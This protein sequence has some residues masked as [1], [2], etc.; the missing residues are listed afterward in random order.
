MSPSLGLGGADEWRAFAGSTLIS[1]WAPDQTE[2]SS[3]GPYDCRA[4][5]DEKEMHPLPTASLLG[6]WHHHSSVSREYWWD[7]CSRLRPTAKG[8]DAKAAPL[9]AFSGYASLGEE[10]SL[11]VL[12]AY[13]NVCVS[14]FPRIPRTSE[15]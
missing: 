5:S 13:L 14:H 3:T 7:M 11:S 2:L 10:S 1:V 8:L 6:S 4:A 15:H 9:L 12:I